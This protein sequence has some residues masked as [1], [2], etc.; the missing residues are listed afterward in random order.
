MS[1]NRFSG[2]SA[3]KTLQTSK[4]AENLALKADKQQETVLQVSNETESRRRGR[5]NGKRSDENFQQVTAY[6]GKAT[7]KQTKM[8]LLENDKPQEFSELI[9]NLL[10]KW[11]EESK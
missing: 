9:D 10:V 3:I 8:R 6:I 4:G 11:L 5:P 2:L 1:K 7:Y